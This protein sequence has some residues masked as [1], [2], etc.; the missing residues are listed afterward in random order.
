MK[1]QK[2]ETILVN[3]KIIHED[4]YKNCGIRKREILWS[5]ELRL[6]RNHKLFNFND[7]NIINLVVIE[8]A[9]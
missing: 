2:K 7:Q 8:M 5:T 4:I 6:G 1:T 3:M 9:K